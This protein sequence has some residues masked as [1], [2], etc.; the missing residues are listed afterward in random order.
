MIRV[1]I[2]KE[3]LLNA[4]KQIKTDSIN[5]IFFNDTRA[6]YNE[7]S[8]QLINAVE[9]CTVK[10]CRLISN[11]IPETKHEINKLIDCLKLDGWERTVIK[12]IHDKEMF[13][14]A[15]TLYF[16][17]CYDIIKFELDSICMNER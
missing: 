15:L 5:H 10:M 1:I 4:I 8:D 12:N 14:Y 6:S 9:M 2:N 3:E 13:K 17:K 11:N 16:Q 7:Y